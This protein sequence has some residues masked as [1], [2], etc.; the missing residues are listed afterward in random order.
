MYIDNLVLHERR[1]QKEVDYNFI[2]DIYNDGE[3][4]TTTYAK[5]VCQLG[6]MITKVLGRGC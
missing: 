6:K 3:K 2:Q 1:K 5:S 4:M